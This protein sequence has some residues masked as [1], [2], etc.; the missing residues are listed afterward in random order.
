MVLVDLLKYCG[1]WERYFVLHKGF[2]IIIVA[3]Y[4]NRMNSFLTRTTV[5]RSLMMVLAAEVSGFLRRFLTLFY[6]QPAVL[7][8]QL[9]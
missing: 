2:L 4:T 9:G 3:N 8:M 5:L 1:Y 6:L 7:Q